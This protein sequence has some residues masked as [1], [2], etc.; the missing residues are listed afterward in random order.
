[1]VRRFSLVPPPMKAS[2]TTFYL[3]SKRR[4][5][6]DREQSA[7]PI[8]NRRA[9]FLSVL[10]NFT[11]PIGLESFRPRLRPH[12]EH[13]MLPSNHRRFRALTGDMVDL[14]SLESPMEM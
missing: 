5:H 14:H 8:Q 6:R 10:G 2:H 4:R 9:I 1:M 12:G 11:Q 3:R 13:W 7:H